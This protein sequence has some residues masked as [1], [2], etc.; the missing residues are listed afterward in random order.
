MCALCTLVLARVPFLS[1]HSGAQEPRVLRA[2]TPIQWHRR[3]SS[4]GCQSREVSAHAGAYG[5]RRQGAMP[6]LVV[7]MR[8]AC[9]HDHAHVNVGMPP[10]DNQLKS[11]WLSRASAKQPRVL[12]ARTP[13][14]RHRR[15]PSPARQ[16]REV[17]AHAAATRRILRGLT[18]P[19]RCG[20]PCAPRA[21]GPLG[22]RLDQ[23]VKDR[24][25][26]EGASHGLSQRSRDKSTGRDATPPGQ[27][28]SGPEP[29]LPRPQA[30]GA[31]DAK[32]TTGLISRARSREFGRSGL[33][34]TT[35]SAWSQFLRVLEPV[36]RFD[37]QGAGT[38]YNAPQTK[39]GFRQSLTG[40]VFTSILVFGS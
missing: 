25:P 11:H 19:T 21:E 1:S 12:R 20:R 31:S 33:A 39:A 28:E 18:S 36:P 14:Q 22:A 5:G 2:R 10:A 3:S 40:T 32:R 13:I 8:T 16:S 7:G 29:T 26:P 15:S 6:T 34:L 37:A 24:E 38:Q 30:V 17:S 27:R 23:V 35:S 9:G 4:P